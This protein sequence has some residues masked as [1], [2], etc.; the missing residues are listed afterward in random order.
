[1]ARLYASTEPASF[2]GCLPKD[3]LAGWLQVLG[4]MSHRG[5]CFCLTQSLTGSSQGRE[6]RG[7]LVLF[8][9]PVLPV[10]QVNV[11]NGVLSSW[12]PTCCL[13][14]KRERQVCLLK[15]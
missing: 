10:Q 8:I 11:E 7:G 15:F 14:S 3:L 4:V 1:M 13:L 12:L 6:S 5:R 2:M 9:V